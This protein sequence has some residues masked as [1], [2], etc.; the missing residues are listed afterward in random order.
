MSG[1]A[2]LSAGLVA[3]GISEALITTAAGLLIALGAVIPYNI[4]TSMADRI[5]LEIEE[6]S[7]ELIEFVIAREA[8]RKTTAGA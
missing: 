3:A 7:S 6:S 8:G 4:F 2:A 5:A 1:A